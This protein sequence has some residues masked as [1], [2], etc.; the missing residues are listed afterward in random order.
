MSTFGHT[1]AST[2][3]Y[4]YAAAGKVIHNKFTLSEAANVTSLSAYCRMSGATGSQVA[5]MM[6][7]ADNGG[8][9]GTLKGITGEINVSGDSLTWYQ[10]GFPSAVGL[11]PADYWLSLWWGTVSAPG[12]L[13]LYY[14]S[15]GG[16]MQITDSETVLPY[17]DS[18]DPP[19]PEDITIDGSDTI[20]SDIYATYTVPSLFLPQAVLL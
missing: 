8:A 15:S 19:S 2:D 5:R 20:A 16:V 11:T 10:G 17:S 6:I 1:T 13:R 18:G 9:P 14:A 12:Y 3:G 4:Y 7:Y